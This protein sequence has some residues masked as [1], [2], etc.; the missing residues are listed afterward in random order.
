MI[1]ICMK[2]AGGWEE[3]GENVGALVEIPEID[4]RDFPISPEQIR[5]MHPMEK[6][7]LSVMHEA[8]R[9][10]GIKQGTEL[11]AKRESLRCI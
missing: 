3:K 4:Y 10:G 11:A 2:S 8:L 7:G 6:V 1:E 9:D 5:H